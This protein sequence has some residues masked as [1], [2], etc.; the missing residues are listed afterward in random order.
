MIE[1]GAAPQRSEARA[2]IDSQNYLTNWN[3]L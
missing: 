2:Q 3:P 1:P